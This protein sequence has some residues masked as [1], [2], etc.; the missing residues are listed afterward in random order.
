[1]YMTKSLA[2]TLNTNLQSFDFLT[3]SHCSTSAAIFSKVVTYDMT[4]YS[5]KC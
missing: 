4:G 2:L 3:P 1:M 5:R